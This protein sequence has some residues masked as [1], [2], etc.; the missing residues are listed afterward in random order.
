VGKNGPVVHE[1][2]AQF[3][4]KALTKSRERFPAH[5]RHRLGD[6]EESGTLWTAEEQG[7]DGQRKMKLER[8]YRHQGVTDSKIEISNSKAWV[9][10]S[11]NREEVMGAA[12]TPQEGA[13]QAWSSQKFDE[14][15]KGLSRRGAKRL[16]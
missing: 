5:K 16:N 9:A 4:T 1:P 2:K 11:R 7:D 14:S 15:R 8:A 6:E 10:Q 13:V 12:T 3:E